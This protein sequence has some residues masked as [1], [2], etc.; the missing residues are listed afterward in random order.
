M[1]IW[2][3]M[4]DALELLAAEALEGEPDEQISLIIY[5]VLLKSL[6]QNGP[7]TKKLLEI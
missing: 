4:T 3:Y 2:P 5:S 6:E 7:H 1:F